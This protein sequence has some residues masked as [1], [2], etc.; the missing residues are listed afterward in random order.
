MPAT[1]QIRN[2]MIIKAQRSDKERVVE[3]L[4]LAFKNNRSVHFMVGSSEGRDYR[5]RK[6]MAYAFEMCYRFG[7]VWLSEGKDA[8][9][10]VLFPHLKRFSLWSMLLDIQL[11]W[12][13]IGFSGV[14]KVLNREKLIGAQHPCSP[15]CY[16]WFIGVNPWVQGKGIGSAMLKEIVADAEIAGMPVY[17]ETSVVEN[18]SWYQKLGFEV[19]HDLDLGYAL[20]F[21][22]KEHVASG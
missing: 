2:K 20:F 14:K 11:M 7:E 13:V 5:L 21:L 16:L 22:K 9:A 18:L 1:A 8:C 3:V 12:C 17:L 4:R 10:L 19:F 15:F 6:L